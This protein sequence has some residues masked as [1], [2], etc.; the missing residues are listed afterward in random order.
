MDE[1]IKKWFEWFDLNDPFF[2]SAW[3]R[4]HATG[5]WPDEFISRKKRDN[6][7]MPE[8]WVILT[9]QRMAKAWCER[10]MGG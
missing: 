8:G 4:L 6:I 1:T 7:E 3:L 9:A 2:C 10:V 5:V